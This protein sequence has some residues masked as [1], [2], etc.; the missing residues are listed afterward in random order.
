MR[1]AAEPLA[2][3]V[4]VGL[5]LSGCDRNSNDLPVSWDPSPTGEFPTVLERRGKHPTPADLPNLALGQS[6][7][8]ALEHLKTY[9]S[10]PV[11]REGGLWDGKAYFLGCRVEGEG[12]LDFVR[13]GFWPRLNDRVA[14]LE[15]K[16][17][18]IPPVIVWRNIRNVLPN[19][20][21]TALLHRLIRIETKRYRLMADWD[22]GHD[23]P[24]H[25]TVGFAPDI[26]P[27]RIAPSKGGE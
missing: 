18:S 12:D 1:F 2:V 8:R 11:R 27:D 13:V 19:R 23:G 26:S 6:K 14:T 4:L 25:I 21:D 24:V 7:E 22:R 5:L 15:V 20:T 17:S 9:C 16:R 3:F 10:D